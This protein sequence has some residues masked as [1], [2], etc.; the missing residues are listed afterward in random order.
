MAFIQLNWQKITSSIND[1]E[2]RGWS[3]SS[4]TDDSS[5]ITATG[6]FNNIFSSTTN[7]DF[8]YARLTD[9]SFLYE[10]TK[11]GSNVI[12]RLMTRNTVSSHTSITT[13]GT[14]VEDHPVNI[15]QTGT[16]ARV[17]LFVEFGTVVSGTYVF[18]FHDQIAGNLGEV[19]VL[20]ASAAG[21]PFFLD[22]SPP[23]PV[24]QFQRMFW[25]KTSSPASS[26]SLNAYTIIDVSE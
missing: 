14:G 10:L 8:L 1:A 5:D 16:I 9:G 15:I 6:Y 25:R 4:T 20:D 17:F 23:F 26:I 2:P 13:T 7:G 19:T 3:Y 21:D 24:G 11:S 18:E 12:L 22:L